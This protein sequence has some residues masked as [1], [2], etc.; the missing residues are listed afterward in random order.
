[1]VVLPE[2]KNIV[3]VAT[4]D[5]LAERCERDTNRHGSVASKRLESIRAQLDCRKSN[6]R[7][8]HR[9]KA[10]SRRR[11]DR[12]QRVRRPTGEGMRAGATHDA[13]RAAV[14]VGICDE[15]RHGCRKEKGRKSKYVLRTEGLSANATHSRGLV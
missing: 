11:K 4:L 2:R 9:L 10:L 8:V 15:T 13:F 3:I 14:E 5:N 1:M 6:V 7:V 12:H